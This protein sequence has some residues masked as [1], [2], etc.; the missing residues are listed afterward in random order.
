MGCRLRDHVRAQDER[1]RLRRADFHE[2]LNA[3][4]AAQEI[5][6]LPPA[7]LGR[8]RKDLERYAQLRADSPWSVGADASCC[9]QR[10]RTGGRAAAPTSPSSKPRSPSAR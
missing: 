4:L 7:T 9:A 3:A 1:R 8:L 6:T 10:T 5:A 2:A